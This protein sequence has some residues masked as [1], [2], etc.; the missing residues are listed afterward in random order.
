LIQAPNFV[1]LGEVDVFYS[2]FLMIHEDDD[3]TVRMLKVRMFL[4]DVNA[5]NMIDQMVMAM[6]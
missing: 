4:M 3:R 6:L 5:L 1:G 2:V